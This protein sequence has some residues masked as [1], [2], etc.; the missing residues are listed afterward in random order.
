M[1]QKQTLTQNIFQNS[2]SII[3]DVDPTEEAA[4]YVEDENIYKKLMNYKCS[5]VSVESWL[6]PS[7]IL[8]RVVDTFKLQVFKTRNDWLATWLATY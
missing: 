4:M 8:I 5:Y 6:N 1:N 7:W 3:F 2:K